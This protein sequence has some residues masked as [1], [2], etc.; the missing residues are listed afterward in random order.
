MLDKT[1]VLKLF[2]SG[3]FRKYQKPTIEKMVDAFNSGVRCILL[4]APTGFGKSIVNTTLCRAFKKS[5]YTTP[6]NPLIDQMRKDRHIGKYFVEIKGRRNY[7]CACDPSATVDVGLCQRLKEF[8]CD[9]V[10]TCTY[11]RRKMQ[12]LRAQSVLTNFAYFILEGRTETE[13]SLGRR[14]LLVLDESHSIDKYVIEHVNF[15]VSPY[16]LPF[17]IYDEIKRF[18]TDF[19]DSV[20]MIS[21][22]K[23]ILEVV[24][25]YSEQMIQLTLD[26]KELTIPQAANQQRVD[27]FIQ[28]ADRFL[29][30]SKNTEWV[31]QTMW[32]AYGS[33]NYRRFVAQPL[34]ARTFMDDMIWSRAKWFI[35]SS[36]TILN[37]T[38][39]VFESGLDLSLSR[40]KILHL[41]VPSTFPPENRPIVDSINGRMT[42][43]E[44]SK[45]FPHAV[46]LLEKIIDLEMGKNIA[47]HC[48]SYNIALNIENLIKDKYKLM[49]ITHNSDDR[50]EALKRWKKANGKVFL[51]VA[52]T[53][54]QNWVG[55]IC[56]AQV[57]FKVPYMD[58]KDK[59][60]ARRLEL[61]DWRWYRFETLKDVIQSYG[62][63]VRSPTD[64][65]RYYV[66]DASFIDLIRRC[67]KDL[68]VWFK[69]ALPEHW[70]VL[71]R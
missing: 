39:F 45:N 67:K 29:T 23:T 56:E 38:R 41:S 7:W 3:S 47:V 33:K 54:G 44:R 13:Y 34:Y 58:I 1:E 22:V 16:S 36:A 68:P 15:V 63:A 69:E 12:A 4:D 64:K 71:I 25:G 10:R 40:D 46:E 11:W 60:V 14:E 9:R 51:C 31:W 66:I 42:Y 53:E 62:R 37:P 28:S 50:Q 35:V 21:F 32:T 61:K 27:T 70:K 57:L 18:I 5:F 48:H 8:Q 19:R 20:E 55:E 65:A 17:V 49:L 6:Q 26:G 52:F 24:K 2:P 30:S 59:R 43:T